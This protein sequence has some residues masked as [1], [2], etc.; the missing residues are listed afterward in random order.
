M[1]KISSIYLPQNT[2]CIKNL[3]CTL[4][5]Y[6][7]FHPD[8]NFFQNSDVFCHSYALFSKKWLKINKIKTSRIFDHVLHLSFKISFR[9]ILF[10]K[11]LLFDRMWGMKKEKNLYVFLVLLYGIICYLTL[12]KSAILWLILKAQSSLGYQIIVFVNFVKLTSRG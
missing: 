2:T 8:S 7:Q 5:L 12:L 4:D 1:E 3:I 6:R 11:T 9:K 10:V